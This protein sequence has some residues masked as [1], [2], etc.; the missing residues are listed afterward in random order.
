MAIMYGI[1][2]TPSTAQGPRVANTQGRMQDW[3]AGKA[4]KIKKEESGHSGKK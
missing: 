3:A 4:K 1:A 2:F